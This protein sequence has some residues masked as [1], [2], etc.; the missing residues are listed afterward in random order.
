MTQQSKDEP[1][2]QRD[3]LGYALGLLDESERAAVEAAFANRAELEQAVQRVRRVLRPLDSDR[4]DAPA[5]LS[6]RILARVDALHRTIPLTAGKA[7]VPA[8]GGANTDR[9]SNFSTR[10]LIGLAAAILI[11]V[12][13]F[14]PGYQ[15]ARRATQRTICANNLRQI[16]YGAVQY[17]EA[18]ANQFPLAAGLPVDAAWAAGAAKGPTEFRHVSSSQQLFPLVQQGYVEPHQ[19]VCAARPGEIP[20]TREQAA[21][22]NDFP[23]VRNNSYSTPLMPQQWTRMELD[24]AMPIASDLTPLVD[25]NRALVEGT[26]PE[27]ST[28]H[29]WMKG[30][31]VLRANISVIWSS[32]PRIGL[33]ADDIYRVVGV[34]RYTGTERPRNRTDAFLIP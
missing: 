18:N 29:P 14:V 28:S 23:D 26:A 25:D 10:D 22:R 17:A 13:I 3:L 12:G 27:N 7:L 24:P 30:Q 15:S 8:D 2:Q 31:N 9:S 21:G 33:D 34:D 1:N 32:N 20:L 16:G 19:F 5:D 11:F 6:S 4:V